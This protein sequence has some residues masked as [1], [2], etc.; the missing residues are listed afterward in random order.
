MTHYKYRICKKCSTKWNV[1][2]FAKNSKDYICPI[3]ERKNQ[4]KS[5]SKNEC[6]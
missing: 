5:I 4:W 3:C 2:I 1:S 6:A